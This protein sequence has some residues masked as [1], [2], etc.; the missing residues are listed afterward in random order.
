MDDLQQD[1]YTKD[2]H[3]SDDYKVDD[4]DDVV[5]SPPNTPHAKDNFE[6]KA[7]KMLDKQLKK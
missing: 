5:G 1:F 2:E 4:D 3:I 6:G 7:K